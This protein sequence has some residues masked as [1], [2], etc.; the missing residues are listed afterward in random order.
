MGMGAVRAVCFDLDGTLFDHRGAA[1]TGA[2]RF[3]E[4]S[5]IVVT[6]SV[7]RSW[8]AA[9]GVQFERWRSGEITFQEQRRARL[10]SVLPP[11][12]I[13]LPAEDRGVDAVFEVYLRA[14]RAAWRA[15]P[16]SASLLRDL[17]TRGYRVGLLTNGTEHQQLDKLARTG[18]DGAF[19]AVCTSER[20]GS[21]KP[22]VRAFRTVA[23]ELRVD[24]AECLFVGDDPVH[25]VAGARAAGMRAL[26]VRRSAG[27]AERFRTA[28]SAA[29]TD[30]ADT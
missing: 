29:I 9:E 18:L 21:Q 13:D 15:F 10:R 14:Y 12:G 4:R 26:L 5:G 23:S 3:L 1:R 24:P 16:G 8:S 30:D 20:I 28:V 11:L 17:R 22:D 19:D 7:L 6:E 25:D 2:T 27:D